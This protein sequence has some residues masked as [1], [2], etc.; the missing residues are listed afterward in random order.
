MA[1]LYTV[2]LD[3]G[4]T[5]I[6]GGLIDCHSG[7]ILSHVK[8]PSPPVGAPAVLAAVEDTIAKVLAGAPGKTRE[9]VHGIGLGL[10]GQVDPAAGVLRAAPNLGGGL[11]N[12][13][14]SAPLQE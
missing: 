12:M 8:A 13:E 2:G 1:G 6:L 9:Q 11:S 5:K 10:A 3:V 14:L 7:E 4:G